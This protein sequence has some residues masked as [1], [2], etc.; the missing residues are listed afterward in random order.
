MCKLM[1]LCW[2]DKPQKRPQF[3]N[4]IS[5]IDSP[6]NSDVD[7]DDDTSFIAKDVS[8]EVQY[9]VHDFFCKLVNLCM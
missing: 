8:E 9:G 4:I 3:S 7:D 5:Y 2:S 6:S 1:I